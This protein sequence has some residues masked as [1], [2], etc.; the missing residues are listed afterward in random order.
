VK[1]CPENQNLV[2]F[3]PMTLNQH[4]S[5]LLE[6]NGIRRLGYTNVP[7]CYTAC[8]GRHYIQHRFKIV[9]DKVFMNSA[10]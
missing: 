8:V 7:Q 5:V 3:L 4:K 10:L 6:R 9:K 1:I 2:L